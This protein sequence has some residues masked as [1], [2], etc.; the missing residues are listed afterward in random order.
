[1]LSDAVKFVSVRSS[2]G[3]LSLFE[4]TYKGLSI[5]YP[6]ISDEIWRITKV[7][8]FLISLSTTFLN[9]KI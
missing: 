9:P 1:M 7:S 3:N 5:I 6:K 4:I 2:L 8:Y